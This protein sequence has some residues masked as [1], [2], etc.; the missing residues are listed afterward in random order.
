MAIATP[1]NM[2]CFDA[3]VGRDE[4]RIHGSARQR[5]TKALSLDV[6]VINEEDMQRAGSHETGV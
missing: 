2:K 1:K 5:A 6:V 3:I 4:L